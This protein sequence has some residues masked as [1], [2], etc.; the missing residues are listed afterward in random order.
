[1]VNNLNLKTEHLEGLTMILHK[2]IVNSLLLL[3]VGLGVFIAGCSLDVTDPN[4]ASEESV[5]TTPQ[6]ITALAVG[7][8]QAYATN[9][10][11]RQVFTTAV[12]AR[13][14]AV[15]N[16][17]A[18]L[19]ELELG[20]TDLSG[21]NEGLIGWWSNAYKVIGMAEDLIE[22]TPNV[23]MDPGTKSGI[24]A[25]AKLI[26]AMTLG[27]LATGWEKLPITT[28]TDG[29]APF[30]SR[31]EALQEAIRLLDEAL[32]EITNTPPSA[33]FDSKILN[34][35]LDLKNTI[36]AYRARFKLFVGDYAGAIAAADAVD[37]TATSMFV[38]DDLNQNPFWNNTLVTPNYAPRDFFGVTYPDADTLDGRLSFFMSKADKQSNPHGYPIDDWNSP[39]FASATASVPVYVPGEMHLIK[40]EAYLNQGNISQAIDEIN[41]VRTKTAAE[42][43][44]GIG[45]GLA[46][47]AGAATAE[48]VREEL[49]RQR[50]A[51][52][53]GQGL[54]LE[55]A[56]R[57]GLPGPDPTDP[58][59]R[60][61]NFYPYPSNER[62]NNPNTPPDPAI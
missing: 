62:Q 24:V 22:N 51:E 31:T 21:D 29:K 23:Q 60:N 14:M 53:F 11:H 59:K 43:P 30:V 5:L 15:N 33:E 48:A 44:L 7:L 49:V 42:D 18:N 38:Y 45:A 17:F 3:L 26:K 10:F 9:V 39:F 12:T 6:G 32:D 27:G 8:Q 57:L 47:Y 41:A 55:D 36:N 16:T 54:R 34:K 52:L 1:M 46:P 35:G 61:R 13:E 28:S 4:S 56:R 20:G 25:L 37:L 50:A 2:R 58:Y 19:V 40:A